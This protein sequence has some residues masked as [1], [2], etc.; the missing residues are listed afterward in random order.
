MK[1]LVSIIVPV[2]NVE[3]YMLKCLESLAKQS[4]EKIEIIIVDDG[5]TDRS[6]EICDVFAKNDKR[7]KVYHKNNGGLSSARNYGIKKAKGDFICLVDSD[8]WVKKDFV[9]RMVEMTKRE[10][11]D[12]VVCGYNEVVPEQKVMSGEEATTK[13]LVEQENLEIVAWNKMYQRSLF[14]DI[15]YPEGQNHED[16]LTTYKLLSKAREVAYVPESLYVYEERAGSIMK[17]GKKEEKLL[18]REKAAREAIDYFSGRADLKEA[19]WIALLTAK[20]AWIDFA[21]NGRVEKKHLDESKKWVSENKKRL[22]G[23]K[24]L[25]LKLKAYIYMV[26]IWGGKPYMAFRKIRHE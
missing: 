15:L 25:S 18:A 9:A 10:D 20:L 2:Y 3:D 11:V 1:P 14:D 16:N 19:A 22:L 8:D 23:N 7:V 4:Y 24:F 21:I 17:K 13:L 26:T 6:G 5:A 12:V